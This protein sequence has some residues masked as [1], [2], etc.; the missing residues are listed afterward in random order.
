MTDVDAVAWSKPTTVTF[1]NTDTTA[2]RDVSLL[3][4]LN[5][6]FTA[7]TLTVSIALHTPDSLHFRED[8]RLTIPLRQA[9]SSITREVT[10]PYRRRVVFDRAGDYLFTI[11]PSRSVTGVE[12]VGIYTP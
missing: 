7:D 12:A 4:R 3:L 1:A 5:D 6:H 10:I 11:I 8:F 2:R 9:P